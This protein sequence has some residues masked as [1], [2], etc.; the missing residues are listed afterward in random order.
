MPLHDG[1]V[2]I[3]AGNTHSLALR[4]DGT[5]LAWGDNSWGQTAVPTG[6]TNVVALAGGQYHSLAL[7]SDGTVVAWGDNTWNQTSVPAGLS[8][9][10]AIAAESLDN[11]ALKQDGSVVMW[12]DNTFFQ[13]NMPAGLSNVVGIAAGRYHALAVVGNGSPVITV[14]PVSQYNTS[15]GQQFTWNR[16]ERQRGIAARLAPAI[17]PG[18][19][20]KPKC[21]LWHYCNIS[22]GW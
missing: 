19:T 20:A 3:A 1:I 17:L 15:S 9:V 13:T 6:L 18:S 16:H 7:K 11:L 21:C 5:V 14:Q 8:N 2:A 22:N 12:G 10:V 4:G